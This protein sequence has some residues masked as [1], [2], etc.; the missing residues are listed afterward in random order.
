MKL[1]W[2][3]LAAVAVASPAFAGSTT[4][5]DSVMALGSYTITTVT[6]PGNFTTDV[7][8]TLGNGDDSGLGT[9]YIAQG[10]A[11]PS[12]RFRALS[13]TF[14]YDPSVS[15]DILSIDGSLDQ[16]VEMIYN[17]RRVSLNTSPLQ[18][19]LLAQQ[20]GQ[21]Y[22][23]RTVTDVFAANSEWRSTSVSGLTEADFLRLD[24]ND[25]LAAPA[26]TGLDFGGGTIRFGFEISPFGVT[27]TDGSPATG[28]TVSYH[29]VDNLKITLNTRD[30]VAAVPEP[31]TWAVMIL[32]FGVA[33]AGLRRRRTRL[34]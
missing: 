23:S 22:R 2:L 4:F 12:P 5:A 18:I 16:I 24:P 26:G 30:G 33:G 21:L 28:L 15:G 19:R 17:S 8:A 14:T 11:S 32:G 29:Y 9:F 25:P 34:V 20:D 1:T 13:N 10:Q 27:L 31:S 6:P 3:A 7:A